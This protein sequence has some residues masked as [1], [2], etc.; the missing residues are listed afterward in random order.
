[1]VINKR[2]VPDVS[3]RGEYDLDRLPLTTNHNCLSWLTLKTRF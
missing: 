1:M 2:Q 3:V